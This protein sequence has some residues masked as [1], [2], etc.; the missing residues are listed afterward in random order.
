MSH[1][2][3]IRQMKND[4]RY[5]NRKFFSGCLPKNVG[6]YFVDG[7]NPVTK[8]RL[9]QSEIKNWENGAL[10]ETATWCGGETDEYEIRFSRVFRRGTGH[11]LFCI[12]LLHE[13][14]HLK[15]RGK[16]KHHGPEFFKE[17]RRLMRIGA[18]DKLIG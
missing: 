10:A 2:L 14:I 1:Q 13:M 5:F 16:R 3:T 12:V 11:N 7:I 17:V 4:Y 6:I 15:L 9:P 18:F 8:Y